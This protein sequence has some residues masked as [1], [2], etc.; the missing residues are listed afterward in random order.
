[1]NIRK[2]KLF[3][4]PDSMNTMSDGKLSYS[5]YYLVDAKPFAWMPKYKNGRQKI[6]RM[7]DGKIL[8]NINDTPLYEA[9]FDELWVGTWK[10][11]HSEDC[12]FLLDEKCDY[13][14]LIHKGRLWFRDKNGN[15]IKAISFWDIRYFDADEMKKCLESLKRDTGIDFENKGWCIDD[16]FINGS[17]YEEYNIDETNILTPIREW[18]EKKQPKIITKDKEKKYTYN[19]DIKAKRDFYARKGLGDSLVIKKFGDFLK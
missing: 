5:T 18:F 15:D 6:E 12:D 19:Q 17:S 9:D 14:D 2:F 8:L 11:G 3:E 10:Q 1:M 4:S 7:K 16:P 13:G